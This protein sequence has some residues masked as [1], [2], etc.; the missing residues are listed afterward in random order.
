MKPLTD[1]E[2]N[3]AFL[4]GFN[5]AHDAIAA[6][7]NQHVA[8]AVQAAF[9][10]MHAAAGLLA[11]RGLT[12]TPDSLANVLRDEFAAML[13]SAMATRAALDIATG[14]SKLQ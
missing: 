13:K 14:N 3:A 8:L 6:Q 2:A 1:D 11:V 9:G 10:A 7:G 12:S 5:G 4:A